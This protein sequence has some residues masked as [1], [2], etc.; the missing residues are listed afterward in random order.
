MTIRPASAGHAGLIEA[1]VSRFADSPANVNGLPDNEPVFGRPLMGFAAGDDPIWQKL[2]RQIGDFYWTPAEAFALAFPERAAASAELTVVS[3]VLPFTPDAKRDNRRQTAA[4]SER[5]ARGKHYGNRFLRGLAG[6]V[7]GGL[8]DEGVEATAPWYLPQWR[9]VDSPRVGAASPWSERHAAYA[10]G[11]GTF[12]L[13]DGLITP[14]GKAMRCGS[15]VAR[16]RVPA[17]PRPSG[18]HHAYCLAFHGPDGCTSC[19]DRCPAG[20]LSANGHDK[21]AC[22]AY[23][24]K[25]N[26]EVIGPHFGFQDEACGLC[27][28]GVPCESGIPRQLRPPSA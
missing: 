27:Q 7:V 3:W 19:I 1:L 5:W 28:T 23:L 12:G 11:L 25:M 18:D 16:L 6:C 9:W 17:T 20:A 14:T 13:C 26:T 21:A 8:A 10:A 15:I 24:L 22:H 2:K 4:P